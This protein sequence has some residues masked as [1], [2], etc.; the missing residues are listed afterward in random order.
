[1]VGA[2]SAVALRWRVLGRIDAHRERRRIV[3]QPQHD[4]V[5]VLLTSVVLRN[6]NYVT[7]FSLQR[8]LVK[9]NSWVFLCM[10]IYI[11]YSVFRF[12]EEMSVRVARLSERGSAKS[13]RLSFS[14][15][16]HSLYVSRRDR[17]WM[18][19]K[20]YLTARY[21]YDKL[22]VWS[23]VEILVLRWT[24][25]IRIRTRLVILRSLLPT[26]LY[27]LLPFLLSQNYGI[28]SGN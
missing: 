23:R 1:M 14:V 17:C 22:L 15:E 21:V 25:I 24:C 9:R 18:L 28:S 3:L 2:K 10:Y 26:L 6:A 5:Y 20:I 12:T 13:P 11:Y 16:N 19:K 27:V 8:G 7:D 4:S